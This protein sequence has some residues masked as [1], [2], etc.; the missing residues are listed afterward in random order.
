MPS[1]PFWQWFFPFP[2][3]HLKGY[4]KGRMDSGKQKGPLWK[5]FLRKVQRVW[6]CLI[7]QRQKC[8]KIVKCSFCWRDLLK[9][10]N[11]HSVWDEPWGRCPARFSGSDQC[12]TPVCCW[13]LLGNQSTLDIQA[14]IWI[15]FSLL[16][17]CSCVATCWG[18]RRVWRDYSG[19]SSLRGEEDGERDAS[20][21]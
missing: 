20:V 14:W 6:S 5:L 10:H 7:L 19:R 2:S 1:E 13:D 21:N 18:G 16:K 8:L 15:N 17:V 11:Y 4:S 12:H 3:S 9:H